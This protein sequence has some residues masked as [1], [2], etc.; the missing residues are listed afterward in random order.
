MLTKYT[1]TIGAT[2]HEV[3]DECLKNWDE[4]AFTLKRT[5]YSGVMRS[6]ST[7]FVFVGEIRD[8]LLAEYRDNGFG[9]SAAVTVYT[10]TDTHEWEAQFSAALDF[11]TIEDENGSLSV[12]ALDDTLAAKLK[13]KKSQKYEFPVSEFVTED[14]EVS[15][16]RINNN[17]FYRFTSSAINGTADLALDAANTDVT[18]TQYFELTDQN[19]SN[20]FFAQH[21]QY[22]ATMNMRI[23]GY[24]RCW[25]D[26]RQKDSSLHHYS[27]M[28]VSKLHLMA[29]TDTDP[30]SPVSL[31][32]FDD[33]IT[34]K[35]FGGVT[36]TVFLNGSVQSS[37]FATVNDMVA[38]AKRQFGEVGYLYYNGLFGVVGTRQSY[39]LDA[40][41][42]DNTVYE[43]FNGYWLNM[44]APKDYYQD[45]FVDGTVVEPLNFGAVPDHLRIASIDGQGNDA[46]MTFS[47][48]EMNVWWDDPVGSVTVC[49]CVRPLDFVTKIVRSI[50]GEST[51]V[52]IAADTGGV[53]AGTV[54]LAAEELRQI[55]DAKIYGTFQNFAD[56]MEAVF[57]YTYAIDDE[58]LHFVHRSSV[59][60]GTVVKEIESFRDLKYSVN[61]GLIYATVEA[62]YAKKEYGEIDGRKEKNFTNYYSTPYTLTD[63]KLSLVSKFRADTYG[64]EFV[65]RESVKETKDTKSDEDVFV[66]SVTS[67]SDGVLEYTPANNDAYSPETCVENNGGYIAAEGNGAALTLTMTSSDG[68]NALSDVA[69][70]AGSALFTAGEIEFTTDETGMPPNLNALIRLDDGG[71]RYEGFI[72]EAKANY[73]RVKGVEYKLIIKSITE[74]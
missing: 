1:I 8:L 16:M 12:N 35:R 37:P 58:G 64:I 26:P 27:T 38:E 59:F 73:G 3:P 74:I 45:K 34:Y 41:W 11:S 46:A 19:G 49:R 71:W 21:K 42:E 54:L 7:E 40:Y 25:L 9:A 14:V 51:A 68:A 72:K 57:G 31:Q 23:R 30:F 33:N 39:L 28:P 62:G 20:S 47:E 6:F 18:S 5:D 43:L 24:V 60:V 44:G 63:K 52:T 55:E 10:I 2:E 22:G 65:A 56:W 66:L 13:S 29:D 36:K 48:G 69:I 50:T 53:L 17:G 67:P 32:F 4:I 61:D 15:R 70:T